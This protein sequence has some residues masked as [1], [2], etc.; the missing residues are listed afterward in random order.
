MK[1]GYERFCFMSI[2]FWT[3]D[4]IGKLSALWT[5]DAEL[6]PVKDT[7]SSRQKLLYFVVVWKYG[8]SRKWRGWIPHKVTFFPS[9]FSHIYCTI[10]IQ[11]ERYLYH[12]SARIEKTDILL[13]IRRFIINYFIIVWDQRFDLGYRIIIRRE[14]KELYCLWWDAGSGWIRKDAEKTLAGLYSFFHYL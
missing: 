3:D 4:N 8:L 7:L 2:L 6:F 10:S 1:L 13:I 9:N 11:F 14:K 12:F 5:V